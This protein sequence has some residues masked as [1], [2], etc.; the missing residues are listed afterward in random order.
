MQ[1]AR[2]GVITRS[3]APAAREVDVEP[4]RASAPAARHAVDPHRRRRA[5]QLEVPLDGR[6][7]IG[8]RRPRPGVAQGAEHRAARCRP[9]RGRGAPMIRARAGSK[10]ART[11]RCAAAQRVA[12]AEPARQRPGQP[13]RQP[14]VQMVPLGRRPAGARHDVVVDRLPLLP[15]EA[16]H[17]AERR[18]PAAADRAGPSARASARS[19]RAAS[20]S[21]RRWPGAGWR[22]AAG[23]CRRR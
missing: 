4:A 12:G 1:T 3:S 13:R 20:A 18:Q 19:T 14:I 22:P 5:A 11:S 8:A 6:G 17:R 15:Q 7:E 21:H 9:R 2:S 10:A 23:R 16:Q